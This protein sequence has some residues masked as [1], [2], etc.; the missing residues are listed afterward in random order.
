MNLSNIAPK[1]QEVESVIFGFIVPN[2]EGK[3]IFCSPG[4]RTGI[5]SSFFMPGI[6]LVY[7]ARC[8]WEAFAALPCRCCYF[9]HTEAL[10]GSGEK[11]MRDGTFGFCLWLCR[12]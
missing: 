12:C 5:V 2:S 3:L 7:S 10:L 11:E 9:G 4:K 6:L 8:Y 1:L